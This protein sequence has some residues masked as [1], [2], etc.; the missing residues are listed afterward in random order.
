MKIG[1][2]LPKLQADGAAEKAHERGFSAHL[3][4][5]G[6]RSGDTLLRFVIRDLPD[7]QREELGGAP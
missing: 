5:L 3:V 4:M 2:V 7:L 1:E 6:D